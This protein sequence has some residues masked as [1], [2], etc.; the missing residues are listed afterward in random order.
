LYAANIAPRHNILAL[1][2]GRVTESIFGT[3]TALGIR[4]DVSHQDL[5]ADVTHEQYE[6]IRVGGLIGLVNPL[7]L[8]CKYGSLFDIDNV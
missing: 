1:R 6:P 5:N 2:R 7:L 3:V 4:T 8:R